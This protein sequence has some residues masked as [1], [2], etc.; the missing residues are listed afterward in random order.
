MLD[1]AAALETVC[2]WMSMFRLMTLRVA[3]ANASRSASRRPDMALKMISESDKFTKGF[4]EI[5]KR[6]TRIKSR[7]K[8]LLS[9][10]SRHLCHNTNFYLYHSSADETAS[11]AYHILLQTQN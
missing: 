1:V 8:T 6:K 11:D 9:P 7:K 10:R 2:N 3:E 5:T 4:T